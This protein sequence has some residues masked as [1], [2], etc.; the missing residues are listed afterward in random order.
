M[1]LRSPRHAKRAALW[2]RKA[3]ANPEFADSSS[4]PGA[5]RTRD[6]RFRKPLLYPTELRDL[7]AC[8]L[9]APL[10]SGKR[11][12]DLET[13]HQSLRYRDASWAAEMHKA[14]EG[15]V[16]SRSAQ[17]PQ[18]KAGWIAAKA[19]IQV[20][21]E[22]A[23]HGAATM[24]YAILFSLGL[25]SSLSLG[26][27]PDPARRFEALLRLF[28]KD[29]DGRVSREEYP[30]RQ[31]FGALDTNGDGFLNL[32][33][34]K[35]SAKPNAADTNS[36][37]RNAP[38]AANE[39]SAVAATSFS[40]ADIAWFET[41]V[42]P[43]L[44]DNC[45]SCHSTKG[46]KV[47][48]GLSMDDRESLMLGGSMGPALVPG[49]PN[50]SLLIQAVRHEDQELTM[51]PRKKL[52]ASA[53]ST[54]EDWV[55]R[56]A[57]W[58]EP[59]AR[60]D[61][62]TGAEPWGYREIDIA[63]A[64]E[65]WAYRLP[66]EVPAQLASNESWP[67]T[68]SDRHLLAAMQQHGLVP[69][70]DADK[71][72]WLRRVTFDLVGLPPTPAQVD[73][74]MKDSST[75]AHEVVVD[76]LLASP[77]FGER[78][79]RHWLDVARYAESSGKETNV[80]YPHAWRY[81]DYVFDAFNKDKPYDQFLKEQLAGDLMPSSSPNQE[82]ERMIATGFLAIGTKGMNSRDRRQFTMDLV[83]EQIDATSQAMLGLT[84][85]CA[86]CHDHKFDPIPQEDYYAVAGIFLSTETLYGTARS[87][88]NNHPSQLLTLPEGAQASNGPAMT[89]QA[90]QSLDAQRESARA[91]LDGGTPFVGRTQ[92]KSDADP[93]KPNATKPAPAPVP[94]VKP[95]VVRQVQLLQARAVIA[96]ADDLEKRYDADGKATSA[97]RLAMGVRDARRPQ[98][99]KVLERGEPDRPG[100]TVKR[101]FVQVL[102]TT[103]PTAIT[104]GSGRLE[105]AEWIAS[106]ANPLTARVAVNRI[107][108]H[109]FGEGLVASTDNFGV[110]GTPPTHPELL[111]HLAL[112][113][114]RG[115]WSTKNFIRSLVLSHAYR[116]SAQESAKARDSDPDNDWLSHMPRKRLEGECIRDAVLQCADQLD[117]A[118]PDGSPVAL[119]EGVARG[120][121]FENPSANVG[122]VRSVYLPV[123]RDQLPEELDLFDFADPSFVTGARE[124]TNVASQALLLMNN[125]KV[126]A[127]AGRFAARVLSA[128][129]D[130]AGRITMAFKLALGREPRP[131]EMAAANRFLTD[132]V[133]AEKSGSAPNK[134]SSTRRD[135]PRRRRGGTA[136]KDGGSPT[137][138][139]TAA[140]EKW[141]A[142]CQSLFLTAEFRYVD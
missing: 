69:A 21:V 29:G 88:G 98:D 54:L 130:D 141:V 22:L 17:G 7:D 110:N 20:R 95:D 34:V 114:M 59:V 70:Q 103:D 57:P 119:L 58:P 131:A 39:T 82:A 83:D 68:D 37:P 94:V 135:D 92:A 109:L 139:T 24:R 79:G 62:T 128:A 56:G 85:S 73:A 121:R 75:K 134:K 67:W 91:L 33:D 72:T 63:K 18:C 15:A 6:L 65:T 38:A 52:Q 116:M 40:A 74:F 41:N 89:V 28:D 126:I 101:G 122:P 133:A 5:I 49:N 112:S 80:M 30:L 86:R 117:L 129:K 14:Q 48:A 118:R 64:R 113:F 125:E 100:K 108:L 31:R 106:E 16:V 93:A 32:E 76:R 138:A 124:E 23:Q 13:A 105:F 42:R 45:M 3:R 46:G 25:L 97:N 107:W 84:V 140:D 4:G 142:L 12:E 51:P 66:T 44:A 2:Q 53:I 132:F 87:L 60:S 9:A 127:A 99:A 90:R 55:K 36:P 47:K 50:A 43:L 111:D 19:A 1:G 10:Q 8:V 102:S 71:L 26:Q 115:N 136:D 61:G 104:R 123:M 81:R 78:W 120:R 27:T 96:L 35:T 11:G 77:Q 137:V